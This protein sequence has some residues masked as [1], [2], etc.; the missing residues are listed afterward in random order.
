MAIGSARALKDPEVAARAHDDH[1]VSAVKAVFAMAPAL[2]QAIDPQSLIAMVTPV[3]MIA[4]DADTVAPPATNAQAAARLISGARLD[5]VPQAG[6]Y[7]FLSA[8]APAAA[9]SVSICALAS[10]QQAAAH[11]RAI[12]AAQELFAPYLGPP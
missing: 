8:C 2:I 5:T 4:G 7:A 11:T 1:S 6:H 12:S 10:P 3:A 9:A